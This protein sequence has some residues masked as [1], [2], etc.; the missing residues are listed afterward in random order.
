M[1]VQGLVLGALVL[2]AVSP[3]TPVTPA[4]LTHTFTATMEHAIDDLGARIVRE[5]RSPGIAIGV[6][7]D[8]RIVYA[9]GFGYA[10]QATRRRVDPGTEFYIGETGRPFTAAALLLLEQDGKLKLDDPV[11]KYVPELIVARGVTIR[12]LLDQTSGLPELSDVQGVPKDRTRTVKLATLIGLANKA[13][14]DAPP[15]ARFENNDLNYLI[16][17]LVVERA[18]AVPLSDFL[19]Q[20]IFIPLVM[21]QTFL[22]GDTGISAQHAVGYSGTPGR[23]A[24]ASSWNPAWLYGNADV[25]S[26]IYDLAKWDIGLPLLLRVDAERAM[27]TPA[28]VPGPNRYGL[29]WVIDERDGK[30]YIWQDGE[31]AGFHSMNALL[32]DDHIAVIVLANTDAA[33]PRVV[34]PEEV[35]AR[36]ID[37]VAPPGKTRVDNAIVA[38]AREWLERIA[39]KRIDRT[40]LTPA[41]SAYLTDELVARA[42]FAALG[43]PLAIVPISSRAGD[44]GDTVY[45]FLVRFPHEQ[46]HYRLRIAADGKIDG[47]VLTP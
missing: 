46:Y 27:F 29:G 22:A 34:A 5:K 16:A 4:P 42:D 19:Q 21:N 37:I 6:V 47:L 36:V 8:G 11:T 43:R 28:N 33:H 24:R 30:R 17:G 18:S 38:K 12:Q 3:V 39:E 44:G 20:H 14:P 9:H 13:K 1:I 25:V 10:D 31:I 32:P 40:Q 15:G 41:F 26:T 7:E 45:E 23:F 35:A 2:G